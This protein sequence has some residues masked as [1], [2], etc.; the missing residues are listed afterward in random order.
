MSIFCETVNNACRLPISL[1]HHDIIK[2]KRY[3]GYFGNEKSKLCA[4]GAEKHFL[5][6]YAPLARIIVDQRE[7][8]VMKMVFIEDIEFAYFEINEQGVFFTCDNNVREIKTNFDPYI[9]ITTP[10]IEP[11]YFDNKRVKSMAFVALSED[12]SKTLETDATVNQRYEMH[13]H[14]FMH[15]QFYKLTCETLRSLQITLL[16]SALSQAKLMPGK[17]TIVKLIVREAAKGNMDDIKISITSRPQPL[18]MDNKHSDFTSEL[19]ENIFL[20]G[21]GW[22]ASLI[23]CSL[24]TRFKLGLTAQER[25]ILLKVTSKSSSKPS[26]YTLTLTDSIHSSVEITEQINRLFPYEEKDALFKVSLHSGVLTCTPKFF[27]IEIFLSGELFYLLGGSQDQRSQPAVVLSIEKN[28]TYQ[29]NVPPRLSEYLPGITVRK[30]K[31][32]Y[33]S[34]D[35]NCED[36]GVCRFQSPKN[37]NLNDKF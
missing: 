11:Q 34:M 14:E 20:P 3:F 24:P 16:D 1:W 22:Y 35:G 18:H 9:L 6:V 36:F 25:S 27:K 5:Y 33:Q 10:S 29:F 19:S 30:N 21:G 8:D 26:R 7:Q 28:E 13:H 15:P 31:P 32:F 2:N 37:W 12:K 4:I 17:A 23:S